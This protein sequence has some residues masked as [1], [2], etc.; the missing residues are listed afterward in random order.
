M[1]RLSLMKLLPFMILALSLPLMSAVRGKV[2]VLVTDSQG[3]PIPGVKISLVSMKTAVMKFEI[4]TNERGMATHGSL[5]NHNFEFTF[6]KEGYQI[7][8]PPLFFKS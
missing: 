2:R 6:E 7:G 5:E 8:S 3:N 1:K 4:T